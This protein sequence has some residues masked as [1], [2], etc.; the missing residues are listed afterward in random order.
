MTGVP[1]PASMGLAHAPGGWAAH[2]SA[3]AVNG[4]AGSWQRPAMTPQSTFQMAPAARLVTSAL[5]DGTSLAH[6]S[7]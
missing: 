3:G 1:S 6:Y 7:G 5:M 4:C 2:G